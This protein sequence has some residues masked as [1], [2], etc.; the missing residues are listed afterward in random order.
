MTTFC[1]VHGAW[2]DDTCWAPLVAVLH[3]GGH[4]CITPVLPLEEDDAGFE[5][6]AKVV[7]DC[8]SECERPVLVGH[9]LSSAVIPLVAVGRP[10]RCSSTCA[11]QWPASSPRRANR[12]TRGPGTTA[13]RS[14]PQAA[15]LGPANGGSLSSAPGSTGG[16]PSASPTDC[17]PSPW[18][19][20]I[21][22]IHLRSR[23]RLLQRS[24]NARED[25]LFDDHW[26]RWIWMTKLRAAGHDI[27]LRSVIEPA[28][29]A[30]SQRPSIRA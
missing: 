30:L 15:C 12:R 17:A 3:A 10:S 5:D 8:L 1:L 28:F 20:S 25:E 6:Y 2:H 23:P 22:R 29:D 7:V 27:A 4:R 19:C 16:R 11:R 21:S 26:S 18:A 14:T 24:C 13:R 9:S